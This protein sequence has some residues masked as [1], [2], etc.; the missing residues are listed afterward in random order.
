MRSASVLLA[1]AGGLTALALLSLGET[2]RRLLATPAGEDPLRWTEDVTRLAAQASTV[3]RP[4]VFLGS[5]S[6]RRW[7]SLPEDMAPLP[8]L[9]RGFGGSR[10]HDSVHW[11][12]ALVVPEDPRALVVFAGTNDLSGKEPRSPSWIASRFEALARLH[13]QRLPGVPL[14]YIAISPTPARAEHL[15]SVL[16]TNRLI[17][18][19]CSSDPDLV[20]VDTASAL[21]DGA[22][23]PDPRWFVED[24]LHLNA[25]GYAHWT[26]TL[27]PVVLELVGAPALD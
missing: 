5:S 20:F 22:G 26:A 2:P 21:L 18:A 15:Q 19:R 16:A 9:N 24:R 17:Q 10:I 12:D 14:V 27:R 8:V 11:F 25:D 4:V 3:E 7:D 23:R 13:K 6:I 1:L